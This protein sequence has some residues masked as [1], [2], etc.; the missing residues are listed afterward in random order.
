MNPR[1]S[2]QLLA[3][4]CLIVLGASQAV[5]Q[6]RL[7]RWVDD[8]GVVHYGDRVPPEYAGR[9]RDL[10]NTQGVTVGAEEGAITDEERAEL[11]RREAVESADRQARVEN[12]RRD[13]VLLDTYLSV[14]EIEQLRDRRLELL[15]AQIKVT[16]QYLANLRKRLARLQSEASNYK[17]YSDDA[18]APDVP[19]NL[20]LELSR[21]LASITVYEQ[22]L[23]RSRA[24]QDSLSRAF[25]RDIERFRELKGG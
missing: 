18:D 7:Y 9:D 20:G 12:A 22:T 10:L 11:E 23:M 6:Q 16:E 8:Q 14:G 25:A 24:E 17:P 21:T 2:R 13:Q 15:A 1:I 19:E 5:A 3:A 4:L